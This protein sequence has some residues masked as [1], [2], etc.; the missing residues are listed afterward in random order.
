[1]MIILLLLILL[2]SVV[3]HQMDNVSFTPYT[4]ISK[5]RKAFHELL[6]LQKRVKF[7]ILSSSRSGILSMNIFEAIQVL[8]R[9]ILAT[10]L[11][12]K[13]YVVFICLLLTIS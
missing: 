10:V 4:R 8:S 9:Y 7:E 2:A 6:F 13:H 12:K 3:V 5:S 1:M 11:S